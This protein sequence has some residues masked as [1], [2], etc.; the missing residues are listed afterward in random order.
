MKKMKLRKFSDS[1]LLKTGHFEGFVVKPDYW[2]GYDENGLPF[3]TSTWVKN[4][5]LK[6]F[7][8]DEGI[9]KETYL[10]RDEAKE[11]LPLELLRTLNRNHQF[12]A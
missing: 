6:C 12:R 3:A 7:R 8:K 11:K 1:L 10:T 2:Y 5:Q 9:W 4:G